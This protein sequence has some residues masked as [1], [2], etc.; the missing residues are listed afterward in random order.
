MNK[1]L[2]VI[3]G[4]GLGIGR[5]VG[6]KKPAGEIPDP[7]ALVQVHNYCVDTSKIAG[8]QAAEVKRFVKTQSK[9]GKLLS[10]FPWT[11]ADDCRAGHAEAVVRI[12]FPLLNTPAIEL[13]RPLKEDASDADLLETKVLFEVFEA[14][15]GKQLYK[16]LAV[17]LG[18]GKIQTAGANPTE[19][20]RDAMYNAFSMLREDL[21]SLL[22]ASH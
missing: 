10:D 9:A 1:V 3:L 13:G 11:L 22:P 8:S 21:R 20:R 16:L 7:A 17:P 14:G 4:F 12:E 2:I 6:Q 19:Q 5:A 18:G 15:S